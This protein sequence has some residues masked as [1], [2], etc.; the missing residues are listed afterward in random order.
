MKRGGRAFD[1][2]LKGVLQ[3]I[4]ETPG[5]GNRSQENAPQVS[6]KERKSRKRRSEICRQTKPDQR[7]RRNRARLT[8]R[9]VPMTISKSTSSRSSTKR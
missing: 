4:E 1:S 8:R 5:V 3:E 2:Q 9:E 6:R 7:L